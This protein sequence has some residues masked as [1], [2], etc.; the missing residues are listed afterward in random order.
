M[1]KMFGQNGW[2]GRSPDET[3]E[4]SVKKSSTSK[5]QD[6]STKT[7]MMSKIK[8]KIEGFVGTF[9][10]MGDKWLICKGGESRLQSK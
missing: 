2:L 9:Q 1:K 8:T 6:Q 7:T 10:L 3:F 5:R 4:E